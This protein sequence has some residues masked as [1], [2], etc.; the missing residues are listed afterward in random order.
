VALPGALPAA[1]AT[2]FR[3]VGEAW[4]PIASQLDPA[5]SKRLWWLAEKPGTGTGTYELRAVKTAFTDAVT[6][7]RTEQDLTVK[8][9]DKPVL[10]YRY[11]P[12][13]PPEGVNARFTR[14]GFIHPLYS[15]GGE[16][17]TAIHPK[18]HYHHLGLWNPWTSTE[19]AGQHVDFWNLGKGEGTVRF[20]R[21]ESVT[22]GPVF[23][24]FRAVLDHVALKTPGGETVVLRELCDVRVWHTDGSF[25]VDFGSTQTCVADQPLKLNAYR[26]GGFGFRGRTGWGDANSDYL[27][28]EGKTRLNG[29]A[30]R[31]RWCHV[32][33]ETP[34]GGAG[35]LFMSNPENREHPEPM[36]LWP[37]GANKGK[38]NVF[39]NF[40]PVQKKP[41]I[42]EPGKSYTLR[43]RFCLYD[44]KPAG[45]PAEPL[46]QAF[47]HPPVVKTTD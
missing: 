10:T 19:F 36:R 34:K 24:G 32:F 22:D 2:L 42:M 39:F 20:V 21:F 38:D 8:V 45:T 44:G 17:L 31:S 25:L 33:G 40:C 3:Q 29:H 7:V 47:A 1:G 46:W 6:T 35:V 4:E 27:T 43:Y 12:M 41:W 23:G 28:S 15:P 5:D 11:A 16:V 18:D 13:P 26:Y 14:S 37:K 30:S 9:G